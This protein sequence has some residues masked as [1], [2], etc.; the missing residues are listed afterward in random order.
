MR[1]GGGSLSGKRFL[2][3]RADGLRNWNN[4]G[5]ICRALLVDIACV[6]LWNRLSSGLLGK[7][8]EVCKR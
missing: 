8:L 1:C 5:D 3:F 6:L 7:K 4:T 2:R